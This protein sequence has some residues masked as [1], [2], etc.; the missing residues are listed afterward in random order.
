MWIVYFFLILILM[1][2]SLDL[3]KKHKRKYVS[4]IVVII[5]VI[6]GIMFG[7]AGENRNY[8][9]Y[10]L[11]ELSPNDLSEYELY[12]P[13]AL[14]AGN[15][16]HEIMDDLNVE[17]KNANTQII[18]TEHGKALR[19]FGTG[20][21]HI[22]GDVVGGKTTFYGDPLEYPPIFHLSMYSHSNTGVDYHWIYYN[23]SKRFAVDITISATIK[24]SESEGRIISMPWIESS[25]GSISDNEYTQLETGW[26][27]IGFKQKDIT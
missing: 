22:Y 25:Q 10:Y 17:G 5:I 23:N 9:Y 27:L 18:D 24:Q 7:I 14:N 8:E 6:S 2:L 12:F 3:V 21:I 19:V 11:I 20:D 15:Q 26:F 16:P 1:V 4:V 13:M